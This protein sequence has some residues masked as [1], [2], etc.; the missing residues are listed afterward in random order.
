[1]PGLGL[2]PPALSSS[3]EYL[4]ASE[5]QSR[6]TIG[7]ERLVRAFRFILKPTLGQL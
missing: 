1:M 6:S 4:T 7:K 3:L 2:L 5:V